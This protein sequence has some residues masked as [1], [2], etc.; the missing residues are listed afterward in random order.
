MDGHPARP[1][2]RSLAYVFVHMYQVCMYKRAGLRRPAK[3]CS[4][5]LA[6]GGSLPGLALSPMRGIR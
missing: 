2:L 5:R 4:R 3:S 1:Q 6:R